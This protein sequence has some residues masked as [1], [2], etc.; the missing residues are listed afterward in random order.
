MNMISVASKNIAAIGYDGGVLYIKFKSGSLH[1][2]SNVPQ[3]VYGA[4]ISADSK[5]RY[6]NAHIRGR[7][8][9]SIKLI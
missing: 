4:F 1:K 6:Y 8:E 2:Y 5:G 3:H 9:K 7:Y